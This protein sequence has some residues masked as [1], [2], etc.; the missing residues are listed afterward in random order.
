MAKKIEA[1]KE[2]GAQKKFLTREEYAIQLKQTS[3]LIDYLCLKLGWT[4]NQVLDN[5]HFDNERKF[6]TYM[7]LDRFEHNRLVPAIPVGFD[8]NINKKVQDRFNSAINELKE[9]IGLGAQK[10]GESEIEQMFGGK[11]NIEEFFRQV[12]NDQLPMK[13]IH[14]G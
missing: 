9:I 2:E 12:S 8:K 13:E 4:T 14:K 6:N 11:A 1:K 7:C 10:P 3:Y 5:A